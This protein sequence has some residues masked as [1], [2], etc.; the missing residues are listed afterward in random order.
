MPTAI[1]AGEY[2]EAI[3]RPH[4]EKIAALMSDVEKRRSAKAKEDRRANPT[5]KPPALPSGL[6]RATP[7]DPDRQGEE[8]VALRRRVDDRGH[9]P[10]VA[11]GTA[12][13]E[14]E[15]LRM[16]RLAGVRSHSIIKY[17]EDA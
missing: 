2:D 9:A 7:D 16:R 8:L 15:L 13:F 1:V 6:Y 10:A 14:I 11:Q 12:H 5:E 4:T 17:R 3:L